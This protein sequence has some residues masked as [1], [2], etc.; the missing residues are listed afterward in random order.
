MDAGGD[1]VLASNKGFAIR[2]E[3]QSIPAQG[4][5]ASGVKAMALGDDDAIVFAAQA[6]DAGDLIL[7]SERGYAKRMP[8]GEIAAQKRGGKGVRLFPFDK[9]GQNGSA[10][11]AVL[12][13]QRQQT[14]NIL[15][16]HGRTTPLPVLDI[17]LETARGKGVPV[18][19]AL[20]DDVV[21]SVVPA[22]VTS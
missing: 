13:A 15:Q 17:P 7:V 21:V 5:T 6:L 1:I 10:L 11:A 12:L 3:A 16:A 20:F 9:D 2:F 18:V 4:R 22:F 14:L 19:M 8:P